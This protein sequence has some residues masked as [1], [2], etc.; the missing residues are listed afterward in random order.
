MRK[1][2]YINEVI[3]KIENKKARREVEKE[4]SAHI[5]DRIS[6]YTDAGW[7]EETANEKTMEHMGEP[8]KVSEEM[9]KL[10]NKRLKTFLKILLSLFLIISIL[11]L[12]QKIYFYFHQVKNHFYFHKHYI[13]VS[14]IL[15][16]FLASNTNCQKQN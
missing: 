16:L 4:L 7:D 15:Q 8:K 5:D 10:H 1:E 14:R 2:E 11:F 6:Y 3:S 9:G 13:Y 12:A